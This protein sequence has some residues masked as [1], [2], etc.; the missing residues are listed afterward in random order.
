[1][2]CHSCIVYKGHSCPVLDHVGAMQLLRGL[3]QVW[4][5]WYKR[6]G[7]AKQGTKSDAQK[8]E[9][10]LPLI[11]NQCGPEAGYP[12]GTPFLGQSTLHLVV[13]SQ[14]FVMDCRHHILLT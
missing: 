3:L 14:Q 6:T 8:F 9:N 5:A 4:G 2:L 11:L 10:D 1:M 13:C 12:A 7:S